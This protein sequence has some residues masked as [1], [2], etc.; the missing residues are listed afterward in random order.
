MVLTSTVKM[1]LFGLRAAVGR[2]WLDSSTARA[3][4]KEEEAELPMEVEGEA[5]S[6]RAHELP[7]LLVQMLRAASEDK[8]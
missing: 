1:A 8:Q 2:C 7:L 4:K 3:C 5:E 6:H